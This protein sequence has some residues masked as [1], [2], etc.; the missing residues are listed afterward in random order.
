MQ[1]TVRNLVVRVSSNNIKIID[2]YKLNN[3]KEMK[4][5]IEEVLNKTPLYHQTRSV[6]ALVRE[7]RSHNILYKLGL[8]K[9]HTKDCDLESNE[10]LH[11]RFVYFFLGRF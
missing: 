4:S 8:F 10:K 1:F 5:V 3:K 2:S 11:R 7:W 9:T 6:K